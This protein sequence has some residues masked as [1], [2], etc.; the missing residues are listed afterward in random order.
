MPL[1]CCVA[2]C[3]TNYLTDKK[4]CAVYRL[5]KDPEDRRKWLSAIPRSNIPYSKYTVV[6]S[7]HWPINFKKINFHGKERPSSPPSIF[8]C[9][10]SSLVPTAP[11]KSRI[12]TSSTSG[13]RSVQADQLE[14]FKAM[15]S[16]NFNDAIIHYQKKIPKD[17][18]KC[19]VVYKCDE[20]ICF[21]S[22]EFYCGL[23]K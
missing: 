14:T 11:P 5:P 13:A 18:L 21:Q 22:T 16:L 10:K 19:I 1:K 6:C 8:N 15:D 2:N 9:V 7:E 20:K 3:S 12:T 23:P 17:L 4:K